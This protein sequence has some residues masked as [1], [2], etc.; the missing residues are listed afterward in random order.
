MYPILYSRRNL[1]LADICASK[2]TKLNFNIKTLSLL[3]NFITFGYKT[4]YTV[5]HVGTRIRKI[6]T[7]LY[8]SIFSLKRPNKCWAINE[9]TVGLYSHYFWSITC[10]AALKFVHAARLSLLTS[11]WIGKQ[12]ENDF[13]EPNSQILTELPNI[14]NWSGAELWLMISWNNLFKYE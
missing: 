4:Y 1:Q 7:A 12:L 8:L 14:W 13:S 3:E 10:P 11:V 2:W 6:Y 5:K 9:R